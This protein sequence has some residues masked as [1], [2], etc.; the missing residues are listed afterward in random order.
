LSARK[1]FRMRSSKKRVCKSFRMRRCKKSGGG[2][3]PSSQESLQP[4]CPA[5]APG[6]T[7]LSSHPRDSHP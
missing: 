4:N 6:G 5:H 2:A 1:S 3:H 7:V